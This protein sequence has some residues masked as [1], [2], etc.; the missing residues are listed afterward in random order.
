MTVIIVVLRGGG[1]ERRYALRHR[2]GRITVRGKISDEPKTRAAAEA[3]RLVLLEVAR[4]GR[5]RI[6]RKRARYRGAKAAKMPTKNATTPA[7]AATN[8]APSRAD[9]PRKRAE[10]M[11]AKS[12]SPP[13]ESAAGTAMR[14]SGRL[15]SL[16]SRRSKPL[17]T[18]LVRHAVISS[19]T[20]P[21]AKPSA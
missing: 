5:G 10:P 19:Q 21:L 14:R 4:H 7:N 15:Q 16:L 12:A 8:S 2:Q 20:P 3:G 1:R 9:L 6:P 13:V 17:R 18:K 11:R